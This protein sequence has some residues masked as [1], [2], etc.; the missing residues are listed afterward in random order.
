MVTT[1]GNPAPWPAHAARTVSWR[2]A[3][4]H[5][6]R[7]DRM[8]REITVSLPPSIA[9]LPYTPPPAIGIALA[10]AAR[11]VIAVDADPRGHI[12]ALGGLLLRTESVSSS[13]IERIDA[14]V[15]DYARAVAGIRSNESASSM[16]AATRAL[17]RMID[18]AGE[19]RRV[20]LDDILAAHRILMADD[21]MD[22]HY[23]G[24]LRDVQNWIG[25]SDHSP[26]GAVHIPPPPDTVPGYMEDLVAF[27]N[28]EK[29]P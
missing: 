5:G 22:G 8:V 14:S 16:V 15:D 10:E 23:A 9:G 4:R 24:R 29:F 28:R 6:T 20:R 12:G 11:A 18:R 2:Q 1:A 27:A 7:A 19:T 13:K 25:G 3:G 21:R 26:I 17:A